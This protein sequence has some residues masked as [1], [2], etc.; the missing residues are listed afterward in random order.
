MGSSGAIST[1]QGSF[2]DSGSNGGR[3]AGGIFGEFVSS[4]EVN[5]QV[6]LDVVGL[7]LVHDLGDNLGSLFVEQ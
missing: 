2:G 4:D 5:W 7:G 3:S 1:Y 6:D